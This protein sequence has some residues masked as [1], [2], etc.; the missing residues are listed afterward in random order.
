MQYC[1]IIGAAHLEFQVQFIHNACWGS[2]LALQ[3][4]YTLNWQFPRNQPLHLHE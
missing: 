4:S 3:S 1:Y 2:L